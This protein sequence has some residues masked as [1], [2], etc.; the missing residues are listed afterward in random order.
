MIDFVVEN[1]WSII[2]GGAIVALLTVARDRRKAVDRFNRI[3]RLHRNPDAG[4]ACLHVIE[5]AKADGLLPGWST[6]AGPQKQDAPGR[7]IARSVRRVMK[8]KR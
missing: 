6:G 5:Q 3:L 1:W 7:V 2:M 8:E 4:K